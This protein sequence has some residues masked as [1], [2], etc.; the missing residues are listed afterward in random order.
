MSL[1]YTIPQ[2]QGFAYMNTQVN[3]VFPRAKQYQAVLI[4]MC[5]IVNI[6]LEGWAVKNHR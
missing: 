3:Y 5:N 1:K 6:Q 4:S 2:L